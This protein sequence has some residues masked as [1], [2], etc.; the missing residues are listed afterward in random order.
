MWSED[1]VKLPV[2][3]GNCLTEKQNGKETL[4]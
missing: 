2:I 4:K 3:K 1:Y